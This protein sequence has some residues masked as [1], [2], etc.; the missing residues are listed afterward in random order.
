MAYLFAKNCLRSSLILSFLLFYQVAFSQYNFSGV[1]NWVENNLDKLGGRAIVMVYKDG[2]LVYN[3]SFNQMNAKQRLGARMIA[4]K[5]GKTAKEMTADYDE[6]STIPLASCSKWLSAAVVMSFID[7]GKLQGTDT[8]GKFL[9]VMVQHGKGNITISQCLSHSTG[10][11]GGSVKE[12]RDWI[13][14]VKSMEEA[15]ALIAKQPMESSP[16]ASFHYS[17]VGLQLA[18]AVVE[19]ISG[20][21]FET[22]FQQRIAQPCQMNSTSFGSKAVSLPAGGA[23]GTAADYMK[24]LQMILHKGLY[25]VKHILSGNSVAMMQQNHVAGLPVKQSPAQAGSWGYGF[26]EWVME[27]ASGRPSD[28][29][30]SPGLFGSFPWIDNKNGYAALLFT[31]NLKSS[32]RGSKYRELKQLV[33]AVIASR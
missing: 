7:E 27:D 14:G 15:V 32:G 9:P 20:T 28:A 23:R 30:T 24:F 3:Q 25:Q 16:G 10:I 8:I 4:R 22:V 19:K 13:T 31:T 33:D 21:K 11:K 6:N 1:S 26:G 12:S 17:S 29:V 2:K 5:S 18:A